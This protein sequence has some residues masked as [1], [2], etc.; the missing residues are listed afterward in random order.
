MVLNPMFL[1][2]TLNVWYFYQQMD[3][4]NRQYVPTVAMIKRYVLYGT[5]KNYKS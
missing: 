2:R 4:L 1:L 5:L 3:G